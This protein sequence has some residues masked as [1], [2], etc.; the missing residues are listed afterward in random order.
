MIVAASQ[1]KEETTD[2]YYYWVENNQL[3]RND[4]KNLILTEIQESGTNGMTFDY[5][6]INDKEIIY[7]SQWIESLG[8]AVQIGNRFE[9]VNQDIFYTIS[10]DWTDLD[11][12][13]RE[14]N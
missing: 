13:N 9:D 3:L 5:S 6:P 8:I 7:F 1:Y 2:E 14:I 12:Y 10:L 11:I 4:Y